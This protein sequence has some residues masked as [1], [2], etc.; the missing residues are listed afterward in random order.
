MT[1]WPGGLYTL[2]TDAGAQVRAQRAPLAGLTGPEVAY[3]VAG[4]K[5]LD[6][7]LPAYSSDIDVGATVQ[8][9]AHAVL[10]EPHRVAL[11][12][13]LAPTGQAPLH[14]E[15]VGDRRFDDGRPNLWIVLTRSEDDPAARL[16]AN[17]VHRRPPRLRIAERL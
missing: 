15:T 3:S 14:R 2:T 8:V 13:V 17:R 5:L 4:E 16:V 10:E 12:L 11:Q 7:R 6:G 9:S 1:W